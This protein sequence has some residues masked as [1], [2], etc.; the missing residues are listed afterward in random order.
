MGSYHNSQPEL[1]FPMLLSP[2][3]KDLSAIE[4]T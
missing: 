3:W 4:E 2:E 1:D